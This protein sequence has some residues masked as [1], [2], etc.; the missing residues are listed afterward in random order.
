MSLQSVLLVIL[1]KEPNT[2]YGVGRLLRCQLSHL[3]DARL[4][5]IYGELAK[6]EARGLVQCESIALHNR[7]AKKVYSLTSAG[8]AALEDW[9]LVPPPS[10]SY[11][12]ELLVRLY[13]LERVSKDTMVRR[14][15][16]RLDDERNEAQR[17]NQELAA[18][19]RTDPEQLGLLLTL[20]AA[21][22]RAEAQATWCTRTIALLA[23]RPESRKRQASAA[24]HAAA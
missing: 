11:K 2:G 14:L 4:Q 18:V 9:L 24:P 8:E 15:E 22:A 5:Q 20:E 16:E 19:R 10:I 1:S 23:E 6:L 17:V 7:P 21:L 3:W 13:C 12:D